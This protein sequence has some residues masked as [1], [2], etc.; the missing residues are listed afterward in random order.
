MP[1]GR[2]ESA[3][4]GTPQRFRKIGLKQMQH[5]CFVSI[6]SDKGTRA[7]LIEYGD[8]D[9]SIRNSWDFIGQDNTRIPR[10]EQQTDQT[11]SYSQHELPDGLHMHYL[12]IETAIDVQ[13]R[14]RCSV[15]S[16]TTKMYG[17][18]KHCYKLSLQ[19]M[20]Q[21]RSVIESSHF[22]PSN[23]RTFEPLRPP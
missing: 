14:V 13:R 19:N 15:V 23:F 21:L 4:E 7:S 9:L 18:Y 12:Q 17:P 16:T 22:S 10:A 6:C 20:R 5:S 11:T 3:Q 8:G 2:P 1:D